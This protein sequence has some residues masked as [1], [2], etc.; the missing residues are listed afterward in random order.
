MQLHP[1][2][3]NLPPLDDALDTVDLTS[4]GR[5]ANTSEA[6][7]E[8]MITGTGSRG[9]EAGDDDKCGNRRPYTVLEEVS[10]AGKI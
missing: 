5:G 2:G 1:L 10:G 6:T 9:S 8:G 4:C 3:S 7:V